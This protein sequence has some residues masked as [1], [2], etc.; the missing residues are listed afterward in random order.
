[1]LDL[2]CF[3][4]EAEDVAAAVGDDDDDDDDEDENEDDADE[5]V[6]PKTTQDKKGK[7]KAKAP[8]TPRFLEISDDEDEDL[9]DPSNFFDVKPKIKPEE[10]VKP[11]HES[12][13]RVKNE[14][15][16][17]KPYLSSPSV[18]DIKPIPSSSKKPKKEEG[19][20][21]EEEKPELQM[22]PLVPSTKVSL[23]LF[24]SRIRKSTVSH[25]PSTPLYR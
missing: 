15:R 2:E 3:E 4:P 7:G 23:S 10:D 16:D 9:P 21:K 22:S 14:D 6:K 12:L 24:P 1:M 25:S 5:D 20:A 18:R 13:S 19:D 8:A 11:K 17:L